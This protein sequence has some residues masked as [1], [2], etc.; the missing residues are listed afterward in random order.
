MSKIIATI[1]MWNLLCT[2]V[3]IKDEE[4]VLYLATQ[5]YYWVIKIGFG[6]FRG[7]KLRFFRKNYVLIASMYSPKSYYISKG[8]WEKIKHNHHEWYV[9]RK[10]VSDAKR[11]PNINFVITKKNLYKL[12]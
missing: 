8:L 7:A 3:A 11:L 9:F 10:D 6:M 12:R 2:L 5:P 1:L 4:Y